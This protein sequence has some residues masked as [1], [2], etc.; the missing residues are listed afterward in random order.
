[1]YLIEVGLV[2]KCVSHVPDFSRI[3]FGAMAL[4]IYT[5]LSHCLVATNK[6][7][8][9]VSILQPI[10]RRER[11]GSALSAQTADCEV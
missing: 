1:M 11:L 10:S 8:A 7:V 3:S 4:L 9:A 2:V 6:N 5:G